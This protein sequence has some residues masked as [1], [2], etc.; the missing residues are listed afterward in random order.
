M[1]LAVKNLPVNASDLRDV[2]SIPEWGRS[3]G[4]GHGSPCQCSCLENLMDKEPGGLVHRVAK[5]WTQLKRLGMHA[6][7]HEIV[8]GRIRLFTNE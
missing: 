1:A 8:V 3:P 2:G 7:T 6:T 4:G 5:S